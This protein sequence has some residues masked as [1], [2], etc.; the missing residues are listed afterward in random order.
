VR[1]VVVAAVLFGALAA[2]GIAVAES[3]VLSGTVGPGFTIS[4]RDASGQPV[5][6][7]SPGPVTIEV[8]DRSDEH[9][10]HLTGP[11]VD[12]TTSVEEIGRASFSLTLADGV[13]RFICDPHATRMRGQFT[14]GSGGSAGGDSTGVG[15]AGGTGGTTTTLPS[16]P[17]GSTLVLT[18]GPGFTIGLKTKSGKRV[19][20]LKPGRYTIL[21]RDRSAAHN[22]HVLGAGV[23]R[24]TSVPGTATQTWK[25]V[26]KKGT[27]VYQCDPHKASM[28]GTVRIA[29]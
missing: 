12:V 8:D 5:S 9:N 7:A 22:A 16:A 6:S 23:N 3:P 27:L 4:L 11:G 25:V 19:T 13:Y 14:V 1:G 28:R 17:V 29:A 26:L 2:T 24:K 20:R 15:G 21:V 10:F 18:S